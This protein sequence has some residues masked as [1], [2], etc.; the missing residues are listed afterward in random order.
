MR[1]NIDKATGVFCDVFILTASIN[2]FTSMRSVWHL[3]KL[4]VQRKARAQRQKIHPRL[5]PKKI[6][7]PE[8]LKTSDP[9]V[10]RRP[11]VIVRRP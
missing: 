2:L 8:V 3:Q 7:W 5:K 1:I 4:T 11:G 10:N 6:L 9:T